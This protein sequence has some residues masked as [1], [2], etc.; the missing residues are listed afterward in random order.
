ME[1]AILFILGI[2]IGSF[3]NICIY[4]LPKGQSVISPPS[5]C[6]VCNT[7]LKPLELIPVLSYLFLRGKCRYC[8][9]SFSLRYPV[10]EFL[11][12]ILFV[13]CFH[14]VGMG[15]E[16][17]RFL[18]LTS[19][20]IVITF[21]DYDHQLILD[22]VLIWFAG[23]GILMNLYIG[24]PNITDMIIAAVTGGGVMLVIAVITRGGMGGGDIKFVA[25]L[26]LWFG[27]KFIILTLFLSFVIGGL[28]SVVLLLFKFKGRKDFIPFGP[29]IAI[30]ALITALYGVEIIRWYLKS[31]V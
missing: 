16:L 9:A 25:V 17:I 3:L 11:T 10:V 13:S 18:I 30:G 22:K 4:R 21:I 23:I 1:I 5:N 2:I 28:G 31:F 24:Y 20:L 8:S 12:G 19:F 27:L 29:F 6:P 7:H 26:G 15:S 14:V